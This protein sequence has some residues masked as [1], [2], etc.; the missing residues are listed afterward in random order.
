MLVERRNGSYSGG[1]AARRRRDSITPRGNG[2]LYLRFLA[3]TRG[4]GLRGNGHCSRC[5]AVLPDRVNP[6]HLASSAR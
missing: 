2:V 3:S 4:S 6:P 5:G 1:E